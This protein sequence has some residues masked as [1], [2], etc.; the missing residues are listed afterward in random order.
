MSWLRYDFYQSSIPS[1]VAVVP[2]CGIASSV[3]LLTRST[4][5]ATGKLA[6]PGGFLRYDERPCDGVRR[7]VLEETS[8]DIAI[9]RLL[10][11]TVVAYPYCGGTVSVLELAFVAQPVAAD[12]TGVATG[13]A[14]RIDYYDVS[15]LLGDA[16]ALAFPEHRSVLERY[17]H[18]VNACLEDP[19]CLS[20]SGRPTCPAYW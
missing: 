2:R 15:A 18:S 8:F 9:E 20:C 19:S 1:A 6:F 3:L 7:E 14:S 13:E 4:E 12:P 11:E 10:C 16:G 17:L 5:P